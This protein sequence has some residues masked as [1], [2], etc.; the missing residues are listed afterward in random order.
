M[1]LQPGKTTKDV[2]DWF[3]KMEGP[4]PVNALGGV[5]AQMPKITSY[6][7]VRSDAGQLRVLYCF[8]PDA[9]DGKAHV[10]HGMFKEFTVN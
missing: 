9:K 10:D 5:A 1:R 7:D 2:A 6:F 3:V 8:V 4:P